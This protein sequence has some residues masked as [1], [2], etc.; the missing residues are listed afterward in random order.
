L[1]KWQVSAGAKAFR[2]RA[3]RRACPLTWAPP[4][5]ALCAADLTPITSGIS[6]AKKA[7]LI[8]HRTQS[9]PA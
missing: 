8:A 5:S 1:I 7:L 4:V 9:S 6:S 2:S 3:K